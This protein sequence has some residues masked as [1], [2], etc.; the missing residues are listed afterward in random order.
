MNRLSLVLFGP[1]ASGKTDFSSEF[2]GMLPVEPVNADAAQFYKQLTIG[3]AKPDWK[4]Q[5]IEHHLFDILDTPVDYSAFQYRSDCDRL[6]TA[7][8]D[9]NRIPLF[10]GGSGFYLK[11]LFF[12]LK[13]LRVSGDRI[14]RPESVELA[15]KS[16]WEALFSVDPVRA[17]SIH[18]NDLYKINRALDIRYGSGIVPSLL[19]PS[20]NPITKDAVVIFLSRD[21]EDIARRVVLRISD[22]IG[23]G[24]IEEVR[25]LSE[26]WRRFLERKRFIGYGEILALLDGS[27]K[28]EHA[29]ELIRNRTLNYVKRQNTFW[30]SLKKSL[31]GHGVHVR[32][33][34]LSQAQAAG[35]KPAD[36]ARALVNEIT[37]IYESKIRSE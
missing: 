22:M 17:R 37:E 13:Q 20:F 10:T 8:F 29:V 21:R 31:V 4:N 11:S 1:T 19:E 23:R 36:C 26:E 3:T 18:P 15:G 33:L 24:W 28:K 34:N 12:R 25:G 32:E 6:T 27:I 5:P 35:K 9:R 16:P 7:L 2:A 30:R 14:R